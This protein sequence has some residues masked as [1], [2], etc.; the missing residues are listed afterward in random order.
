MKITFLSH[1]VLDLEPYLISSDSSWHYWLTFHHDGAKLE[2]R[3]LKYT[4]VLMGGGAKGF[5][6]W[7][8]KMLGVL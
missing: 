7:E 4:A 6:C 1:G 3:R 8:W 5:I 2:G